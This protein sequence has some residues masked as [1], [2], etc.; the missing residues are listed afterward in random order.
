MSWNLAWRQSW[1]QLTLASD[2]I[3]EPWRMET[4]VMKNL[5]VSIWPLLPPNTSEAPPAG[6][7]T[8]VIWRFVDEASTEKERLEEKQR[9]A[10][11]E[12]AKNDEEWPTRWDNM[13][14]HGHTSG[15][16]LFLWLNVVQ[17][18][19]VDVFGLTWSNFRNSCRFWFGQKTLEVNIETVQ[20][21][22]ILL[23]WSALVSFRWFKLG[24]NTHTGSQDWLYTGGYFS[25]N[26]QNLPE[27]Y[28]Q[29]AW[30]AS[31]RADRPWWAWTTVPLCTPAFL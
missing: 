25:R 20:S 14:Q 11:K 10:R 31:T 1:L 6:C 23:F 2:R 24:T 26:Y 27:I 22:W 5:F 8:C 18:C 28:W 7:M 13:Q 3:S 29:P 9:A 19:T 17:R 21:L 16:L 30:L 15:A 4:W 12:R